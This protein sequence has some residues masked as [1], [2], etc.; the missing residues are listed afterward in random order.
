MMKLRSIA[1]ALALVLAWPLTAV[2]QCSGQFAANRVCGSVAG[3][4]PSQ[5][6][7]GGFAL[8]LTNAPLTIN[9]TAAS[10]TQGIAITQSGPASGV[11]T[12]PFFFNLI[13]V[14][15]YGGN[16][17]GSAGNDSFGLFNSNVNA[18]RVN[19]AVGAAT[20]QAMGAGTFAVRQQASGQNND[21]VGVAGT[22]YGTL[23]QS[24]GAMFGVVAYTMADTGYSGAGPR[25][26]EIDSGVKSGVAATSRA[27][28][29]IVNISTGT[30]STTDAAIIPASNTAGGEWKNIILLS[31]AIYGQFPTASTSAFLAADTAATPI[32]HILDLTNFTISGN[33]INSANATL[34]GDG[35]LALSTTNSLPV[36]ITGTNASGN[37]SNMVTTAG[38]ATGW[39]FVDG[40]VSKWIV[41]KQ[42]DNTFIIRDAVNSITALV[43]NPGIV[44]AG[45]VGINYTTDASST[46][47]GALQS[48]GGLG[49]AKTIWAGTNVTTPIVAGG[50]G[51]SSTLKL[52]S[53]SGAGTTDS[54][55]FQTGSQAF[56]GKINTTQQWVIGQNNITPATGV[57]LTVS[58]NTAAA[59][60][61]ASL[62]PL[63]HA[64]AADGVQSSTLIDSF[65]T[66]TAPFFVMRTARG[67]GAAFTPVQSQDPL[68]Y[69]GMLG[70]SQNNVFPA[71]NGT[72]SGV[73]FGGRASETWTATANGTQIEIYTTPNTTAVI[74]KVATF[75]NSGGLSI[76]TTTDPGIGS[77][78]LNA[79]MFMPNITTTSAAQTGTVC[80]TTGTGKFTVDTTLGCLSS[81]ERWKQNITPLGSAMAEV[82]ALKPVTYEWRNPIGDGQKGQQIGLVAED[83]YAIDPRLAG[84]GE[85][86]APR[87]WRQD[88]MIATLVRAFQEL[89]ADNDNLRRQIRKAQ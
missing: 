17:A 30:G 65:G 73:F 87:G 62:Q 4:L 48:A 14:T 86:G 61:S 53:T 24:G 3:G 75:Q 19:L 55:I 49:V 63:I 50:S 60:A 45:T 5:A 36:T 13:N 64:I 8:T 79:Q 2:A 41:G 29:T 74:A 15:S 18:L 85:D 28:L 59:V 69:F 38:L 70:A 26:L 89:K 21:M 51:A 43:G 37:I 78:Q 83:V 10:T 80:W 88:A 31:K 54:I 76:G 16:T 56:A 84:L 11:V 7:P 33:I 9:P 72:A 34:R 44:S 27:G 39:A 42:T 58:R 22:V 20:G 40:A 77:L 52:E 12:G 57:P 47:T 25:A 35:S 81:S 68:G 6:D 71:Y 66:S 23:A 67:T 32:N 1:L 82:M 46:S